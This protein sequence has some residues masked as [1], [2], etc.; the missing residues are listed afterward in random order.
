MS[1]LPPHRDFIDLVADCI[2]VAYLDHGGTLDNQALTERVYAM[3]AHEYN[4]DRHQLGRPLAN[5]RKRL[6]LQYLIEKVKH[7]GEDGPGVWGL[8]HRGQAMAQFI[9]RYRFR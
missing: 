4:G 7:Q 5:A 3:I 8:T 9:K 2:L 1:K 6:S